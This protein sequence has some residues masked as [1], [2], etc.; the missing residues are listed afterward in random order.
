ML[1][2]ETIQTP[3]LYRR[4]AAQQRDRAAKE[5]LPNV[6]LLLERSAERWD[7]LADSVAPGPGNFNAARQRP[8]SNNDRSSIIR[9][10]HL[11]VNRAERLALAKGATIRLSPKELALVEL[12]AEHAGSSVTKQ[13]L[14]EHIYT[15]HSAPDPKIIDVYVCK[16][17]KKLSRICG[18]QSVI[19]SFY[20][21][22]YLLAT[23]AA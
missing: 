22:G 4:L 3:Q 5:S 6:R 18:G 12:L 15:G 1:G 13:M 10:G 20:R 14:M 7:V 8:Q 17:R 2:N 9:V 19:Q 21:S 11:T 23:N 16:L